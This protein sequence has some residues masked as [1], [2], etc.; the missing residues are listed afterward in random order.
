[1]KKSPI[2]NKDS[3]YKYL[4]FTLTCNQYCMRNQDG[5]KFERVGYILLVW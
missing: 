3:M 1:M 4:F 5:N 2:S